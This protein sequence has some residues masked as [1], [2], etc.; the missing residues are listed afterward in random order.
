MSQFIRKIIWHLCGGDNYCLDAYDSGQLVKQCLAHYYSKR[1]AKTKLAQDRKLVV[2]MCDGRAYSG[3]L[4]DRLRGITSLY[5]WC[6]EEGIDFKIHFNFPFSLS[7][8]LIPNHYDWICSE[9]ELSY[10]SKESEPLYIRVRKRRIRDIEIQRKRLAHIIKSAHKQF[11]VYTN[12]YLYDDIFRERFH[13]LFKPSEILQR[14]ID[15]NRSLIGSKYI[16]V[17]YRFQQLLG[18]FREDGYKIL[19]ENQRKVLLNQCLKSLDCVCYKMLTG[20]VKSL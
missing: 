5:S 20:G 9:D 7:R 11:H 14:E 4:S 18:D 19:P 12:T 17:V 15:Q 6:K 10:N 13:E 1:N 2:A 8:F 3:G 16:A